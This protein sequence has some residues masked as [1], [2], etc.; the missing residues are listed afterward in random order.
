MPKK[1]LTLG[2]MSKINF[3]QVSKYCQKNPNLGQYAYAKLVLLLG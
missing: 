3:N 2:H 1:I